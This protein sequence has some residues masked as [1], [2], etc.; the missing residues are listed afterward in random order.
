MAEIPD[1]LI[2][3]Q[4][5]PMDKLRSYLSRLSGQASAALLNSVDGAAPFATLAAAQAAAAVTPGSQAR[6]F[7]DPDLT[8]NGLY[9]NPTGA[10]GG[11]IVDAAF[12]DAVANVLQPQVDSVRDTALQA[13]VTVTEAKNLVSLIPPALEGFKRYTGVLTVR[14]MIASTSPGGVRRVAHGIDPTDGGMVHYAPVKGPG[15]NQG[16]QDS[17]VGRALPRLNRFTGTGDVPLLTVNRR[18]VLSAST[19][20]VLLWMGQPLAATSA[21]PARRRLATP[22]TL[23]DWNGAI[24]DGQSLGLGDEAHAVLSITQPYGNIMPAGGLKA[25]TNLNTTAPLIEQMQG[26][27]GAASTTSGETI[28]SA[29]CNFAVTLALAAGLIATPAQRIFYG[30]AP[31]LGGQTIAQLSKGTGPYNRLLAQVSGA[32]IAANAAVKTYSVQT[33]AWIQGEQDAEVG[34]TRAAYLAAL[35][36]LRADLDADIKAITGQTTPVQFLLYQTS[37]RIVD[38]AG[39]IAL[40]QM[41]AVRQSPLFHFVTPAWMFPRYDYVHLT[42]TG[43]NWM[44]R[45]FGRALF[46]MCEGYE[47]DTLTPL[48]ATVSTGSAT[49]RVKYRVPTAPIM[50]GSAALPGVQDHGMRVIDEAGAIGIS[51]SRVVDGDTIELTLSRAPGTNARWRVGLD[52]GDDN[53][54][55]TCS[56]RD[57]TSEGIIIAG[58]SRALFHVSPAFELN[59]ITLEA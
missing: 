6:V 19:A 23:T 20:G 38:S 56:V 32:K 42:A 36:Q 52:Y 13:Q 47:P 8:K 33:I 22:L 31:G 59:I 16:V 44:G 34:T 37:H 18:V 21:S 25:S 7:S 41:D 46:Q 54:R 29:M 1:F 2:D 30:G 26:A 11:Y 27:G 39:R 3:G 58:T 45:Y 51:D 9:V 57:S 50:L 53:G 48:S 35:L 15:F 40:A 17:P 4:D 14:P 10:V 5:P 49:L 55:G 43:Y 24:A 28:V 12:Y